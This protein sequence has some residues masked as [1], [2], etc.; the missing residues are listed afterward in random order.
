MLTQSSLLRK[1]HSKLH[2]Q[3]HNINYNTDQTYVCKSLNCVIYRSNCNAVNQEPIAYV[4][5]V[6][7]LH[8]RDFLQLK[9]CSHKKICLGEVQDQELGHCIHC[10]IWML[11]LPTAMNTTQ[12]WRPC[13]LHPPIQYRQLLYRRTDTLN[14]IYRE[15]IPKYKLCTWKRNKQG[16]CL[17]HITSWHWRFA[18]LPK[19]DLLV[20]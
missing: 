20:S 13:S 1:W 7:Q 14:Y 4:G 15:N 8:S 5:M 11:R 3:G 17:F 2:D 6:I 16:N 18:S 19:C 12:R 10:R 9:S